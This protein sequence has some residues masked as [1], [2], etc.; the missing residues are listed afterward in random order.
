MFGLF[1]GSLCGGYLLFVLVFGCLLY[2]SIPNMA[3][4]GTVRMIRSSF[5]IDKNEPER[6][7]IA[8]LCHDLQ[9]G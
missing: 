9:Q 1:F 2:G 8:G 6:K 3:L 4:R 5:A 7:I